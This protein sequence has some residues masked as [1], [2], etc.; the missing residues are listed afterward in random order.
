MFK[1]CNNLA[2]VDIVLD[3]AGYHVQGQTQSPITVSRSTDKERILQERGLNANHN[4]TFQ[5]SKWK[6]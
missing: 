4:E 6:K 3:T 2:S 5:A 1:V